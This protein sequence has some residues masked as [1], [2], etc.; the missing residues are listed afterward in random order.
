MKINIH[1]IS[2]VRNTIRR[3]RKA[4]KMAISNG[5]INAAKEEVAERI[6]AEEYLEDLQAFSRQSVQ[7][8]C[9]RAR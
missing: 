8:E 3:C 6:R 7:M 5:R 1:S 2:N 9:S 4:A